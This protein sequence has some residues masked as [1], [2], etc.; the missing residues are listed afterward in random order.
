MININKY[1]CVHI[2]IYNSDD[3]D[4]EHLFHITVDHLI[5]CFLRN[6]YLSLSLYISLS[7]RERKWYNKGNKIHSLSL[8]GDVQQI[9]KICLEQGSAYFFC[10][11]PDIK[12]F[13]F[14]YSEKDSFHSTK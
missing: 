13:Q 11:G 12:S 10:L 3:N 8:Y 14:C 4:I 5:F 2:Y 6:A 1:I 9:R 7:S